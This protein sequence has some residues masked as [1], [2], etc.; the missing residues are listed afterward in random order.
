[1]PNHIRDISRLLEIIVGH[2]DVPKSYYE[3]AAARHRSLG[4]W[5]RRRGS[6]VAQ[7]DPDI[8][9]Q[10][11][12]RYGTVVR[13]VREGEE[14]DLDNVCLLRNL[15]KT[16]L[17]QEQLK[18]M[19]GEEIKAYAKANNMI[20]PVSEHNRCWRLQYAD[21]VEFHLD[22]LPCVPDDEAIVRQ[23]MATGVPLELARRVVAITDKRH[24]HYREISSAWF[25]SNPRGFAAWFEQRAA[26]GRR[27]A[28][29]E[30]RVCGTIEDVPPYEWKTPLQQGI[31]ILKRHRDVMFL[32]APD[33]APISMIITNLAARAYE[34][35]TDLA[36]A[37]Q[38]IVEKMPNFVR[39]ERPRLPNPADPA[40]DY[41]DKWTK[42]PRLEKNFWDWHT[43][44]KADLAKLPAFLRGTT[45]KTDIQELF[46]VDLTE[47][48]LRQ[49]AA[50]PSIPATAKAA[51]VLISSAP[52]PWGGN[53]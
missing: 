50:Q 53:G 18:Q 10:G 31:Q 32:T 36:T 15:G 13:P 44:V 1:M 40:E 11:S 5:L 6:T 27:L 48:E 42:D 14:Y 7:F 8:R 22:T 9:P 51:P 45:L 39:A 46:R 24:P 35:E 43:A 4:E 49:L 34:G 23:V 20:A 25:S 19:F 37:L 16:V 38:N 52:K 17:T 30:G 41:A 2:L 33:L 12:C 3:K 47:H 29:K 21:E 28:F 26:L